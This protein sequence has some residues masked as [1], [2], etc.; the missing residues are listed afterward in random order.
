ML[1][2]NSM[3][4]PCLYEDN[5]T[6]DGIWDIMEV[7]GTN[8]LWLLTQFG[9]Y[10]RPAGDTSYQYL[11]IQ[12]NGSTVELRSLHY[13]SN[14]VIVVS[15]DKAIFIWENQSWTRM[16]TGTGLPSN[17]IFDIAEDKNDVWWIASAL[18]V[19]AW[20]GSTFQYHSPFIYSPAAHA[21]AVHD[22]KVYVGNNHED[23]V[24]W[25]LEG[26]TWYP[27]PT[28]PG[29]Q[30]QNNT[31][32]LVINSAGKLYST[33][34]S[35]ASG[36][37]KTTAFSLSYFDGMAWQNIFPNFR[38]RYIDQI[39]DG[40]Y[41]YQSDTLFHIMGARLDTIMKIRCGDSKHGIFK[42][43]S[44]QDFYI[45]PRNQ[46]DYF[47][48]AKLPGPKNEST[49][50]NSHASIMTSSSG[51]LFCDPDEINIQNYSGRFKLSDQPE[52]MLSLTGGLWIAGYSDSRWQLSATNDLGN[53]HDFSSGPISVI[54][55]IN[56]LKKYDRVWKVDRQQIE[57]HEN[58]FADPDYVMPEVIGNWPGN[59]IESHGE[60]KILAPF[61]DHNNN[62]LYEP[63]YGDVPRIKGDKAIFF[64]YNDK[65]GIHNYSSGSTGLGVEVHGMIYTYLDSKSIQD[66]VFYINYR[67]YNRTSTSIDSLKMSFW[68]LHQI[69]FEED[70]AIGCDSVLGLS[71]YYNT[72]SHDESDF[73][74]GLNPPALGLMQL[75]NTF[76]GFISHHLPLSFS[77][78]NRWQPNTYFEY[79]KYLNLHWPDGNRIRV[80]SPDGILGV[81][82]GDGYIRSDIGKA[83]NYLF[84]DAYNW[85]QSPHDEHHAAVSILSVPTEIEPNESF[86]FELAL[87][88]RRSV[89]GDTS[90]G[91]I[92][93]LILLKK[94]AR[95]LRELPKWNDNECLSYEQS[96]VYSEE[97]GVYPNPT[98]GILDLNIPQT[99][100]AD[101]LALYDQMGRVIQRSQFSR[102]IDLSGLSSGI[103]FLRISYQHKQHTVKIIKR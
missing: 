24:I 63:K 90:I 32:R 71:Y 29:S 88:P 25:T 37:W 8:E 61:T 2:F 87:I 3:A 57:L 73:G 39:G 10:Y 45:I 103:Y 78:S 23:D 62:G 94:D 44:K 28:N 58:R 77:M 89:G 22:G 9:L 1:A 67:I 60:A 99:R 35:A 53:K 86:C 75:G 5:P 70:N 16:W 76:S 18:G 92:S 31:N 55:D 34:G 49:L 80:E 56:Y 40:V 21:V 41:A 83:T 20:D 66:S 4:Q 11:K 19:T 51:Q 46:I 30:F 64:M 68:L 81:M 14:K 33:A 72:D 97:I 54:Y 82:N 52:A 50:K 101:E 91:H 26:N 74:F 102:Q 17:I 65:R 93:S 13:L 6:S 15:K 96:D 59:G 42:G 79:L 98:T 95:R 48:N 43:G 36:S 38:F 85:Y 12:L 7:P 84:N 27:L 100:Y 47:I 69:G